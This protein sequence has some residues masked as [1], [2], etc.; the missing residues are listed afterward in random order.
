MKYIDIVGKT[1]SP[2]LMLLI[3]EYVVSLYSEDTEFV[4]NCNRKVLDVSKT[5]EDKDISVID[6]SEEVCVKE[7]KL[8]L[9]VDLIKT[10]PVVKRL[11]LIYIRKKKF[12]QALQLCETAIKLNFT[13][14]T[15]GGYEGRKKRILRL[16]D[17]EK[18]IASETQN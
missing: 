13:D 4:S 14:N 10:M 6:I 12:E 15:V 8:M 7:I 11:T 9:K 2:E 1:M 16:M 5:K 17:K 3:Y 18:A